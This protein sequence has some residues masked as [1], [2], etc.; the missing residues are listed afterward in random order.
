MRISENGLDHLMESEGFELKAYADVAGF[1]TIGVGHLLTQPEI[2]SGKILIGD[3]Q[4][5][6]REGLTAG[7]ARRLLMQDAAKAETCVSSSVDVDLTQSQFDALV[8]FVFNVGCPAFLRSTLLGRLNRQGYDNVPDQLRRWV[9]AGGR[10]HRGL[11]LRRERE[12]SL[13]SSNAENIA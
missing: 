5:K 10:K 7:Q 3:E 8:S 6:W 13:W 2:Y 12:I 1:L 4:V 9:Y 11:A